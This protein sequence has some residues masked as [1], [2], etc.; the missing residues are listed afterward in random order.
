MEGES[1]REK[2]SKKVNINYTHVNITLHVSGLKLL[3]KD[4]EHKSYKD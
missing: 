3:L 1:R 4:S 2:N